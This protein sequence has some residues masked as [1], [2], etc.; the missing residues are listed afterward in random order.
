[1]AQES[2]TSKCMHLTDPACHGPGE[3]VQSSVPVAQYEIGEQLKELGILIL[4]WL[5]GVLSPLISQRIQRGYRRDELVDALV[6]EA[7]GIQFRMALLAWRLRQYLLTVDGEFVRW[8]LPILEGYDGPDRDPKA[9]KAFQLLRERSDEEI[10]TGDQALRRPGVSPHLVPL[11]APFLSSQ[12]AA[13]SIC[14]LDFQRQLLDLSNQ[15][16]LYNEEVR[17]QMDTLDKTFNPG[18]VGPNREAVFANLERG[19][20]KL[21][22]RAEGIARQIADLETNT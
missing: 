18:I 5:L 12:I 7:R 9:I 2:M 14:S 15:L 3:G 21:A 4:G 1:M 10:K 16:A 11:T 19:Y 6:A 22:R 13:I 20:E 8:L 17:T